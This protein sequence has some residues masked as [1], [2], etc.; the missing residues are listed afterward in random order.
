MTKRERL[1]ISLA[2][3]TTVA[4]YTANTAMA[5]VRLPNPPSCTSSGVFDLCVSESD[6]G[7]CLGDLADAC[8]AE[9]RYVCPGVS[10]Y[11]SAG[12]DAQGCGAT[13]TDCYD[14]ILD[15]DFTGY[16]IFCPMAY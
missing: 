6:Y 3:L 10:M 15:E 2:A 9:Y 1:T 13:T 12:P 16:E 5:A 4:G 7:L 8:N 14:P 11:F